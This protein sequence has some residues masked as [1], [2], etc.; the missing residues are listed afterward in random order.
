M[1]SKPKISVITASK[2]G[3]RFLRETIE[4]IR[5]QRFTD[6]EHV[7]ADGASTD[8]TIDILKEY[9]HIKWKSEPDQHPEEGFAK[10]LAMA[11]GEYV[12][13][14]CVSDGY[15]DRD[16]FKKC[17]EVLDND[18]EVSLVY[19]IPQCILEDGTFVRNISSDFME[20]S[21]PQKTDF[22][23]FWLGSFAVCTEITFCVRADVFRRCFPQYEP[24]GYFL[25]S[26]SILSFSYNF[27]TQG[28]L[29]YFLPVI[30]SYGR[31][32]HDSASAGLVKD[33]RIAKKQYQSAIMQYADE[34]LSGR[35]EHAFRDGK[36][37]V[38]K[39]IELHEL[40]RCRQRVLNCRIN[41]KAYLGK[42]HPRGH[43]YYLRKFRILLLYCLCGHRIFN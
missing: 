12:M 1:S 27:N 38:I 15:L 43:R 7:V 28:Y 11:R 17:V 8:N 16:W 22:F 10:A 5:Q 20:Q 36:S 18:P 14:C 26:H 21:P 3:G 25:K 42:K 33:N 37:E 40:K 13:I 30:A 9:P 29:P 4:S 41:R 34:V 2:N 32:H 39:V 23:A 31:Y 19:G 6:Y 35:R 24:S